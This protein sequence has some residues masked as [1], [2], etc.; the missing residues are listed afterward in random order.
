MPASD[1]S[2]NDGVL[3]SILL[4]NFNVFVTERLVQ[5]IWWIGVAAGVLF[6]FA[7]LTS[8]RAWTIIVGMLGVIFGLFIYRIWCEML[9]VIFRIANDLSALRRHKTEE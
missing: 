2:D 6:F 3:W 5:V 8:D 4:G 1:R 9:V 7:S